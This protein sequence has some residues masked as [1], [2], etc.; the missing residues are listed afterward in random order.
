MQDKFPLFSASIGDR[1]RWIRQKQ[2]LTLSDLADGRASTAGSWEE[3]KLPRSDKWQGIAERLRVSWNLI[4]SG[5]PRS[6]EDYVFLRE[7]RN[8]LDFT[9][10]PPE[11]ADVLENFTS[12]ESPGVAEDVIKAPHHGAVFDPQAD[13]IARQIRATVESSIKTAGDDLARLGWILEQS[14]AHLTPPGH[15]TAKKP[16]PWA[17]RRAPTAQNDPPQADSG[18]G[19]GQASA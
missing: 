12:T 10:A 18:G 16:N 1:I 8:S 3:G 17:I 6:D 13:E 19:R 2:G 7:N 11:M 5:W 15:W 9:G 4:S 14:K